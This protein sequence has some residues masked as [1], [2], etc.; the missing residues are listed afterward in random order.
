MTFGKLF[1]RM[2][3]EK[4][5]L[6]P[7]GFFP[8]RKSLTAALRTISATASRPNSLHLARIWTFLCP[9]IVFSLGISAP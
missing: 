1:G 5:A 3:Q 7:L 2:S 9:A 6:Q 4:S 8:L